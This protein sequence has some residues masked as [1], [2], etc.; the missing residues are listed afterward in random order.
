MQQ[1]VGAPAATAVTSASVPEGRRPFP[2]GSSA[3]ARAG[4]VLFRFAAGG[5]IG[6][7]QST[8]APDRV[9]GRACAGMPVQVR[10]C[11]TLRV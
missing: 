1:S 11:C 9:P 2:T 10:G 3:R 6:P 4:A 5:T 7:T 8:P